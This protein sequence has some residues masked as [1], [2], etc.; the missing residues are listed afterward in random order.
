[1]KINFLGPKENRQSTKLNI[2]NDIPY[3][4]LRSTQEVFIRPIPGLKQENNFYQEKTQKQ[5]IIFSMT[6]WS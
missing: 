2:R 3:P 5:K 1:M 4:K 6:E